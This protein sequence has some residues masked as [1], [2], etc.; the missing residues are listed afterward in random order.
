LISITEVTTLGI[1]LATLGALNCHLLRTVDRNTLRTPTLGV[2]VTGALIL[3]LGA[4]SIAGLS[5]ATGNGPVDSMTIIPGGVSNPD[6]DGDAEQEPGIHLPRRAVVEPITIRPG[7]GVNT[8]AVTS[9]DEIAERLDDADADTPEPSDTDT[10]PP[11]G[12]S[13]RPDGRPGDGGADAGSPPVAPRP[14]PAPAVAPPAPPP[15]PPPVAPP[16]PT[17]PPTAAQ[18]A[19]PRP[20]KQP[21][22]AGP[23]TPAPPARPAAPRPSGPP[24]T[25]APA[26]PVVEAPDLD[27]IDPDDLDNAPPAG[28]EKDQNNSGRP[29]KPGRPENPGG[30]NRPEV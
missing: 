11:G 15:A 1:W 6:D 4:A 17:T 13:S 9:G 28:S 29:D 27:T 8:G 21:A 19:P 25:L 10:S 26:T 23:K 16:A 20:P 22:P 7:T 5:R 24:T 14:A 18:P 3:T 12:L 30:H 2:L